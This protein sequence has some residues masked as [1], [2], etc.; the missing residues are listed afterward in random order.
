MAEVRS[1]YLCRKFLQKKSHLNNIKITSLSNGITIISE[2]VP[3]VKSFSLGFWFPVG[4]RDENLQNNGI[5]HFIEHMVFK[6]TEK[7][8]SRQ[9]SEAIESYGGYLNAFT[10][11]EH[12]CFYSRGLSENFG[13]T[14]EVLADMVENPLFREKDIKKESGVVK[15]ELLDVEDNPEEL[16]FDKFEEKIFKGN[17]L[18]YPIL[19]S[20]KNL[21]SFN[22]DGLKSYHKKN[23][24]ENQLVVVASG[25][26]EHE[27]IISLT[28]KYLKN[29]YS[30]SNKK[31]K[32]TENVKTSEETI[33]KEIQQTHCIIGRTTYGY[34]NENRIIVSLIS[35][36]L[37]DGSS[38]RLYQSVREKLGLTYQISSFINSYYDT[39]AFGIYF[40]TNEK[41]LPRVLS[42]IE[43]EFVKFNSN[44]ISQRELKRVKEY[45]KGNILLGLE[46][47]TN[48]MIRMANSFL[49]FG[50]VIPIEEIVAKIENVSIDQIHLT[51]KELFNQNRYTKIFVRSL[52]SDNIKAA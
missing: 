21:E 9:I 24:T 35:A 7:R 11:K 44:P 36:L 30:N 51:S 43:K 27:K 47:T 40:S 50:R 13:R 14:F 32:F 23:Y 42:V 1:L 29:K 26:V 22:S 4:A 6:G 37:G 17:N 46:N 34:N 19:G 8:S 18:S 49:Y 12:T 10:S 48:R 28:E 25:L 33:V 39:S 38:S 31:R 5:S 20:I 41:Y 52:K 15:D 3:Y 2:T 45:I 16:I